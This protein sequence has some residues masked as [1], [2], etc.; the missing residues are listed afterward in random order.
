MRVAVVIPTLNEAESIG[1]VVS[2][3]SRDV[4]DRV[5]VADGGSVDGTAEQAQRAGAEVI[6]AGRGYGR[7][8]L[9]GALAA[10]SADII[11]FMD[12]DGA[13]DPGAITAIVA[14]IR[15]DQYDFV[16]GSR[17]RGERE[18]GSIASHQILVGHVA[19]WLIRLLYG[20]RYTDM[21][22][23]RAIR[24]DTLL[25]LGMRELTYGWNLEMQMRVARS[26]L[27]VLE[28]PVPYRRRIG[29]ESK[30]AGSLRGTLIA[31]V[32]IISTFMRIATEPTRKHTAGPAQDSLPI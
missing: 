16:I 26:G 3:L 9:T 20:V 12:G 19:G 31:G 10:A 14:P 5:I 15:A 17:A 24:R 30:V 32:R 22:A 27:R 18:P 29:G 21:C 7:A 6:A 23:F 8:C 28:L 25:A 13:D 2:S 11:V 4:I 1:P